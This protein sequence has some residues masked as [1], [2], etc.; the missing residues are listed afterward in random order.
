[1][2]QGDKTQTCDWV[3]KRP[4]RRCN[5]V[6]RI[7][8]TK[9]HARTACPL[10]CNRCRSC[11]D[12]TKWMFQGDKNKSCEWVADSPFAR[13]NRRGMIGTTQANSFNSCP[14][15]CNLCST[16]TDDPRWFFGGDKDKTCDWV[17]DSP[18]G[19]CNKPGKIGK[20]NMNSFLACPAACNQC[21]ACADDP[22]FV[23]RGAHTTCDWVAEKPSKR[24]DRFGS[25][26]K[27][28]RRARSACPVACNSC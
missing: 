28:E 3:A 6:G 13:C 8:K 7:G 26:G 10:T 27:T 1:V 22:R 17:A 16:C 5:R 2:F 24:C 4:G 12:D 14:I 18:F 11:Q 25:I 19:R 20:N 9:S 23:V 21:S 15:A